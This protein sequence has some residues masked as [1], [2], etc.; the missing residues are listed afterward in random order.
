MSARSASPLY[1]AAML[2]LLA[3][4]LPPPGAAAD[5][6]RGQLLYENHCV[7]CHDGRAHYR[8]NRRASSLAEVRQWVVKWSATLQLQ[9]SADERGDVAA[10]LYQRYYQSAQ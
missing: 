2:M 10:Y 5:V 4:L 8:E 1:P 6:E 9:W 7:E 3:M